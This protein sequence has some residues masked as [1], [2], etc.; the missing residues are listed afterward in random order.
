M[1]ETNLKG[2][3]EIPP[4]GIIQRV[5]KQSD[6]VNIN[7]RQGCEDYSSEFDELPDFNTSSIL[8]APLGISHMKRYSKIDGSTRRTSNVPG[9]CVARLSTTGAF[10]SP[11]DK[12]LFLTL[13]GVF[14]YALALAKQ[15]TV[16]WA[17]YTDNF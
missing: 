4:L 16:A 17:I 9:A 10:F 2:E 1:E 6:V 11:R 12:E 14:T 8:A 3:W 13:L 5:I 15:Q 7:T